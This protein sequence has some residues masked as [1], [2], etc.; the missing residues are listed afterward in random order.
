[1]N[2][3][4]YFSRPFAYS[5]EEKRKFFFAEMYDLI[6]MHCER[7]EEYKNILNIM[8]PKFSKVQ[9]MNLTNIPFLPV[10]IFKEMLLQSVSSGEVFK[11][12][13]SS[14]TTS[15]TLSKIILDRKT[16][17]LQSKVLISIVNDFI[18]TKRLPMIIVDSDST[19]KNLVAFNARA[20][21]IIGFSVFGRDHFYL[22]DDNME[23]K[24]N[25]LHKFL[26]KHQGEK[27]LVF[28]FTFILWKYFYQACVKM[29]LDIDLYNSI[30]I[31]GGGWKKLRGEAV[32]EMEFKQKLIET[33][34]FKSIHNYYGFIE[35][36][37]S[38]F[39]EC[40]AGHFHVSV[41]S[42]ILIRDQKNLRVLPFGQIGLIQS[43][44][45]LPYS[46]PGHSVLTEDL[47]V[48][49]GENDCPCGRLGK[50]FRV[51]GRIPAAE[52]RGCSDVYQ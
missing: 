46:Y 42:E 41:F 16:A 6:N 17:Q 49:L 39:M 48:C 45:L 30:A 5:S 31:H 19:I 8:Y 24:V 28:G 18:G 52:I 4:D 11:T 51:I 29:G 26:N 20:A 23:I 14:G 27:I 33:F 21:G 32:E 7:C 12:L 47:G 38:I 34:N 36:G 9:D 13:L 40:E 3:A 10:T 43:L 2:N 37:G 44:S 35:Q 22:L 1:M 15:Q 50:Y 25:A